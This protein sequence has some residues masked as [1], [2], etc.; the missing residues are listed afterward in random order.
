MDLESHQFIT[1]FEAEQAAQLCEIAIVEKYPNQTVIFE[2]G[3]R[4]DCLYLLLEG[5]VEFRKKIG[6]NQ[7]RKL[8]TAFPNAFFGELGIIDGQ[9]RS[10]QAIADGYALLGRVPEEGFMK[11]LDGARSSVITKLCSY[12]VQ[13]LRDTTEEYIQQQLHKE[14]MVLMGEMLNTVI[15]DFKSPLSSIN[16]A[17]SML[18]EQH[19]DEETEEWCDLIQAQ[20]R[21]MA[22]MA[23]DFL[24]FARGSA[25]LNPKP[26]NLSSALQRFEKLNLVYFQEAQAKVE[27]ECPPDLVL[28]IDEGKLLRVLQNLVGNAVDAFNGRPGRIEILV[29]QQEQGVEIEISDNGPGIPLEIQDRL[30]ESFVTHGKPQGTGLG[31]AIA[32]SIVDA[33]GGKIL[34]DSVPG[35]GTTF[36]IYLPLNLVSLEDPEAVHS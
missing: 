15:H 18:K 20:T 4:S 13:R 11:V 6:P 19:P 34:F 9:P 12:M 22:A 30:F 16:L 3:A 31:T 32:K 28:K 21:R 36:Y 27:I 25:V 5:R 17:S 14:K 1:F 26:V 7:Y 10:A 29:T 23:E 2:E 8:T 35:Q 33:H 24:E